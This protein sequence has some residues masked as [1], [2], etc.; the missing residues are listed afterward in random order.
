[1]GIFD[2]RNDY[3]WG[4][5]CAGGLVV[6][7]SVD[8]SDFNVSSPVRWRWALRNEGE[9]RQVT[10]YYSLDTSFRYRLQVFRPGSTTPA[11]EFPPNRHDPLVTAPTGRNVTVEKGGRVELDSNKSPIGELLG[12]GDYRL[13]VLFGGPDFNFECTSGVAEIRIK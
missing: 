6:G 8:G 4:A 2:R 3:A 12:P 13:R 9:T 1:L 11:Y 5:E 7:L 10:I